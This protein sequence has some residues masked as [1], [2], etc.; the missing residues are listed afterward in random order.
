MDHAIESQTHLAQ[1]LAIPIAIVK[2][3]RTP[4]V[5]AAMALLQSA[6]AA[7]VFQRYGFRVLPIADEKKDGSEIA[8][9]LLHNEA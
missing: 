3:R 7:T 1:S 4:S 9:V 5:N 2:G 8:S 6:T